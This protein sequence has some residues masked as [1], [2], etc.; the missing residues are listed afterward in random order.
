MKNLD[1]KTAQNRGKT[2]SQFSTVF[3]F[4]QIKKNQIDETCFKN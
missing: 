4:C 1:R 3:L 2:F